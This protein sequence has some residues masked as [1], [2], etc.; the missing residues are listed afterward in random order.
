[1][2]KERQAKIM[3]FVVG[4]MQDFRN[5][6]LITGGYELSDEGY[7]EY[8]ELVASG[9]LPTDEEIDRFTKLVYLTAGTPEAD[10]ALRGE[11]PS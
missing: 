10:I 6:G 1:M 2:D 8:Q 3:L 9:F 5:E 7:K 11:L 4:T